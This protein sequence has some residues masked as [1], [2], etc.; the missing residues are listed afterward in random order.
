MNINDRFEFGKYKGLRLIDVYQGTLNIDRCLLREYVNHLLNTK[1]RHHYERAINCLKLEFT[2]EFIVTESEIKA[3]IYIES[4]ATRG[5][6]D[7]ELICVPISYN[8]EDDLQSYLTIGNIRLGTEI[9]GFHSLIEFN[10]TKGNEHIIGGDPQYISWCIH[11]VGSFCI[12]AEELAL[13]EESKVAAFKGFTVIRKGEGIFEYAPC[14]NREAYQFQEK[15]KEIN[16]E[17]LNKL[18]SEPDD[19]E[20]GYRESG[21]E[22][23][24]YDSWEEMAY[25]EAFEEDDDAWDHYNQ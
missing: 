8:L 25:R 24:G 3:Y 12:P 2:D 17:K 21:P 14:I 20:E 18:S 10:K 19:R 6:D 7:P 23:Y 1:A 16:R 15:V 13:L 4:E 11:N 22:A 5:T 9:G